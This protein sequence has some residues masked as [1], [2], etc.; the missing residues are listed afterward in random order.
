MNYH[1]NQNMTQNQI[2]N[3]G[4]TMVKTIVN[5]EKIYIYGDMYPV[6]KYQDGAWGWAELIFANSLD[7]LKQKLKEMLQW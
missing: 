7:G 5:Q 2:N 6:D 1:Q 4:K 3:E